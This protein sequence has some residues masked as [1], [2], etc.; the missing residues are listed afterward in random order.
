[1]QRYEALLECGSQITAAGSHRDLLVALRESAV[2]LLRA[3]SCSIVRVPAP[4]ETRRQVAGLPFE[5]PSDEDQVNIEMALRLGH[6]VATGHASGKADGFA[7]E[8]DYERSVLYAPIVCG[9]G[10]VA[11]LRAVHSSVKR[12]F[13]DEEE[14]LSGFLVSL[15]AAAFDRIALQEK[16]MEQVISA[17]DGERA[18]IARDLHDELGQGLTSLLLEFSQAG[19]GGR[20]TSPDRQFSGE[21]RQRIQHLLN[22]VR[23]LA[24]DLHPM[25]LDDLGLGAAL[26][27]LAGDV[28]SRNGITVDL[29][30]EA[31]AE[32][33]RLPSRLETTIY[34][35]TQEALTNVARHAAAQVCS[36]FIIREGRWLK[37]MVEDDGRGFEVDAANQNSL[38]LRSMRER[39]G[40]VGGTLSV[41]SAAKS[42]T[43][44]VL[45]VPLD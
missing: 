12:M 25:I 9:E 1:L 7:G 43:T 33:G 5:S 3:E 28:A 40:L 44:V 37:L 19:M 14:N 31:L 39:A 22:Q 13:D 20:I 17:Q 6:P 21:L 41:T 42:G 11:C 2:V 35:V 29:E 8:H 26:S 15:G 24:F 38:G 16:M 27:R 10:P 18:R 30:A 34:R 45:E 32:I 4:G 23:R 36:V